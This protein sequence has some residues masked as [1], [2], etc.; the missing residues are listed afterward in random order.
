MSCE[1]CYSSPK[2]QDE[3]LRAVRVKAKQY[4]LETNETVAIY[5]EGTDY[6]YIKASEAIQQQFIVLE[7]VSKYH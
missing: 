3:Q 4:A 6:L 1:S 5:K 7:F 2:G